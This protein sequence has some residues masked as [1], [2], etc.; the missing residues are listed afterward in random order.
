ISFS[1]YFFF[2][3]RRRHTRSTSDWSSDVCFPIFVGDDLLRPKSDG[4]GEFRGQGPSFVERI[5]VERLRATKHRGEGLNR[6]AHDVVVGLLRG[7]RASGGLR[8]EAQGPGARILGF[9]ALNH[10]F[11][12]DAAG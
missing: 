10:R 11:V 8:V 3:S 2:S 12:P 5:G 9:V 7:Q 4:G 1:V 6:G